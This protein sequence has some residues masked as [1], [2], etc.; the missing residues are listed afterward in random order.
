QVTLTV[1]DDDGATDTTTAPVTVA[2][3]TGGEPP[4]A[5]FTAATDGL[6]VDLDATTSSHPDG[7]IASYDWAFG[8]GAVGSGATPAHGPA[9]GG[10]Y[11]VTLTVTDDD[12]QTDSVTVP[13]T[14]WGPAAPTPAP[15]I[16]DLQLEVDGLGMDLDAG[17]SFDPDGT[18]VAWSWDLGDGTRGTG[19][20]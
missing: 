3:P 9:A 7:T 18:V 15:P 8:D 17:P 5:A 19:P 4:V 2:E 16:A 11:P 12:G 6:G 10:T 1:T 14:V 20:T 13:V